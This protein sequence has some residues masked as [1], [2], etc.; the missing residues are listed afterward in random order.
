[1]PNG[2]GI[3]VILQ[4]SSGYSLAII[5]SS[6]EG[7]F[8]VLKKFDQKNLTTASVSPDSK[9]VVFADGVQGNK[10]IRII[11]IKTK[12]ITT[13]INNPAND[14]SPRWSPDG[15]HIIFCSYRHGERAIWGIAVKGTLPQGAP[16]MIL[17]GG[18]D[19]RLLNWTPAGLA[20]N[21]T[22]SIVD[23]YKL[24]V[25]PST[26]KSVGQPELIPY[27]PTG[28]NYNGVWSPDGKSIAFMKQNMQKHEPAVVVMSVED[29][30][31]REFL[32]PPNTTAGVPRWTPDG[33]AISFLGSDNNKKKSLYRL[34]LENGNWESWPLEF[35]SGTGI[36]W[37]KDGKTYYYGAVNTLKE[38][39]TG[40]DDWMI[41]KKTIG[42][43]ENKIIYKGKNVD[44]AFRGFRCSRDYNMLAFQQ[45]NY[46]M[47]LN[48][49]REEATLLTP[50]TDTCDSHGLPSVIYRNPTWS[51]D[52]K[53]IMTSKVLIS[54]DM[55]QISYELYVFNTVTGK[56]EK[57]EL[58]NT[59]PKDYQIKAIDWSPDGN[60]VLISIQTWMIADYLMKIVIPKKQFTDK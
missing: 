45:N 28:A 47:A 2:K 40:N 42:T 24:P 52:G 37:N 17:A 56:A 18:K 57:V 54:E 16:F 33:K 49:E 12:G 48:L 20:L 29:F 10:N 13:L 51:P 58:G 46:V 35:E 53:K 5:P 60:E 55:K 22:I 15:N 4:D 23:Q 25:D 31:T 21:K 41:I 38:D 36:E 59:L 11:D 8:E 9:Y 14:V 32:L 34:K 44:Y 19:L 50:V 30:V 3:V 39:E 43:P 6:G 1:L 7:G 27:S 26:G